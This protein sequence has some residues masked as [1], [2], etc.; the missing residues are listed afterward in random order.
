MRLVEEMAP[1]GQQF[2]VYGIEGLEWL[3]KRVGSAL[4]EVFAHH[5]F[6]VWAEIDIAFW[7]QAK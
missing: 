2:V 6:Q 7:E 5:W 1:Q 4:G 3:R